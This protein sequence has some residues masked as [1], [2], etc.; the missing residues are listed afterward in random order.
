MLF[1][2]VTLDKAVQPENAL[3]PTEFTL[4]PM[5]TVVS[6]VKPATGE[7]PLTIFLPQWKVFIGQLENG[8]L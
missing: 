1:G 6:V 7:D 4:F 3:L 2:I 8:L 5:V